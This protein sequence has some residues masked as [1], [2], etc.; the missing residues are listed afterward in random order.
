[1][2]REPFSE[3]GRLIAQED[4]MPHDHEQYEQLPEALIQRLREHERTVSLLTPRTDRAVLEA[5]REQFGVR[6]AR[7]VPQ[8]RWWYPAAVAAAV[9][10]VALLIARPFD[11]AGVEALRMAEDV[12][13]SGQVDVLDVFALARARAGDPDTV[14]QGRIDALTDRIVSLGA[15][16][17]VL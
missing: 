13:G 4:P 11:Q 12:D 8:R 2:N 5:A 16:G 7:A 15:P 17:A 3:T 6:R 1:L 9:A 14:S 10:L